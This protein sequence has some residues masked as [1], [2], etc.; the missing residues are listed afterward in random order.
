[1]TYCL[2]MLLLE[3]VK[4]TPNLKQSY[5]SFAYSMLPGCNARNR[6]IEQ[7]RWRFILFKW[8][9]AF[10]SAMNCKNTLFLD[11]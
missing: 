5:V 11:I 1:M 4:L 10:I 3:I 8:T 2:Y 7:L 9:L 6:L